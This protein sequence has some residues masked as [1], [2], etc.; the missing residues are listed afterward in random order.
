MVF[1]SLGIGGVGFAAVG[2]LSKYSP[3]FYGLTFALLGL[4]FVIV[5]RNGRLVNKVVYWVSVGLVV[6]MVLYNNRFYFTGILG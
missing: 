4:S 6:S 3:I 5:Q 1:A 2:A